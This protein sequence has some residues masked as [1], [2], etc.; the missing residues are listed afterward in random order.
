MLTCTERNIP[1]A[2]GQ[3][4]FAASRE[5]CN[6][7]SPLSQEF[8]DAIPKNLINPKVRERYKTGGI[9]LYRARVVGENGD[10]TL[11]FLHEDDFVGS[12]SISNVPKVFKNVIEKFLFPT[13]LS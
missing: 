12:I 10:S 3:P 5:G 4:V 11:E 2:S 9:N 13:P 7:Y 6:A 1:L 8:V